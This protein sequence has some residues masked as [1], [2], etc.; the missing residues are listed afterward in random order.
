MKNN[1]PYFLFLSL[2]FLQWS[3]QSQGI[4]L[5]KKTFVSDLDNYEITLEIPLCSDHRAEDLNRLVHKEI[6]SL[7]NSFVTYCLKVN[8]EPNPFGKDMKHTFRVRILD[9]LMTD[10]IVSYCLLISQYYAGSVHGLMRFKTFN[11][12]LIQAK[13]LMPND[14]IS[15]PD[16]SLRDILMPEL[17]L[18]SD[19]CFSQNA[20]DRKT[21]ENLKINLVNDSI[22]FNFD[23]YEIGA[24]ACGTARVAITK[25]R[26]PTKY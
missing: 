6:D 7:K 19:S 5:D 12:D 16:S 10:K 9:S 8:K 3:A 23:D 18:K 11:F 2:F 4:T 20:L 15:I 17:L 14:I 22:V 25:S 21:I 13:Y 1:I 26:I 24:Y